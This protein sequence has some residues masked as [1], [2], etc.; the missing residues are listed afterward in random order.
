MGAGADIL[1]GTGS[2]DLILGGPGN[3]T[4]NGLTGIDYLNGGKDNDTYVVDV[5]ADRILETSA[6]GTADWVRS[7]TISLNLANYINVEHAQLLGSLAGLSL[8]G[9]DKPTRCP[10]R[11][12]GTQRPNR[13]GRQRQLLCRFR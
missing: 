3:D 2:H 9:N 12:I 6:G 5:A 13:P 8:T 7:S 4:L 1:N 10:A 11:P